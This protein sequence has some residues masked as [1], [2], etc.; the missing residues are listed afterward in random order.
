MPDSGQHGENL[1]TAAYSAIN[2]TIIN[3]YR[4]T[5][6]SVWNYTIIGFSNVG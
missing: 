5:L 3:E 4:C 2:E 6:N 1:E